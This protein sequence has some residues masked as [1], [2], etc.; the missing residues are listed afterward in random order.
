MCLL[1]MS[2]AML[3]VLGYVIAQEPRWPRPTSRPSTR[4]ALVIS[5]NVKRPAATTQPAIAVLGGDEVS[6]NLT[7][8][9]DADCTWRLVYGDQMVVAERLVLGGAGTGRFKFVMPDVRTRAECKL[10]ASSGLNT[11]R[12]GLTAF[13]RARLAVASKWI[14]TL[15]LGVV[16]DAGLVCKTLADEGVACENLSTRLQRD[17]F[18]GGA[19]IIAGCRDRIV[20]GD[21]CLRF[22]SRVSSGMFLMVVNPPEKWSLRGVS[23]RSITPKMGYQVGFVNTFGWEIK[24]KDLGCGPWPVVLS[25][26]NQWRTLIWIESTPKRDEKQKMQSRHPL[27]CYRRIG[28][29]QVIAATLPQLASPLSDAVGRGVLDSLVMWMLRERFGE[30]MRLEQD[31]D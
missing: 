20:L 1:M 18:D 15:K 27:A 8:P 4:P 22:Q 9:T 31:N 30:K 19:V 25:A 2:G 13:P 3:G 26:T 24:P 29:G 10:T 11:D 12:R 28:R 21:L 23:R 5:L 7:G 17:A 14:K 6:V 16:D